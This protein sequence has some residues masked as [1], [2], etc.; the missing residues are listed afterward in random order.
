MADRL[1]LAMDYLPVAVL[2]LAIAVAGSGCM[3]F[4]LGWLFAGPVSVQTSPRDR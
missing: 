1:R 2:V 3:G 4:A